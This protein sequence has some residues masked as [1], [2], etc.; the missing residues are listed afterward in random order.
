MTRAL[1]CTNALSFK[2]LRSNFNGESHIFVLVRS[3]MTLSY[4]LHFIQ[5]LVKVQEGLRSGDESVEILKQ[6]ETQYS[7]KK[8]KLSK[9]QKVNFL[10]LTFESNS[11]VSFRNVNLLNGC[12]ETRNLWLQFATFQGDAKGS[13]LWAV[14]TKLFNG[15]NQC[16]KVW[17]PP[18]SHQLR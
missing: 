10:A 13:R 9:E 17:N 16:L 11:K 7:H 6:T 12:W 5:L 14:I 3:W 1:N 18:S 2:R 8:I 4:L 15:V